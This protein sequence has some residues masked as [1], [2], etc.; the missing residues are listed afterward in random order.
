L[1]PSGEELAMGSRLQSNGI[2][3]AAKV[4]TLIPAVIFH[5]FQT[6]LVLSATRFLKYQSRPTYKLPSN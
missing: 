6:G 3:P 1:G 2:T 5:S 4:D